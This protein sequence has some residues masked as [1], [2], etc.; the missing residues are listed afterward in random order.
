MPDEIR[1]NVVVHLPDEPTGGALPAKTVLLAWEA[2][3][4]AIKGTDV[5]A[6]NF[7]CGPAKQ[8]RRRRVGRPK[9]T[10]AEP[11]SAA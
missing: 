4:A 8:R 9:L 2:F 3:T 10:V 1:I 7:Y 6:N 5:I 11:P